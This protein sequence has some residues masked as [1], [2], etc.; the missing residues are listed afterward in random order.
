MC[1]KISGIDLYVRLQLKVND[2]AT[3][4]EHISW[5]ITNLNLIVRF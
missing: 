3:D 5:N 4:K 1:D 2:K